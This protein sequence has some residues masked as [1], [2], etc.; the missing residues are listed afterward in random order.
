MRVLALD[1]GPSTGWAMFVDNVCVSLGTIKSTKPDFSELVMW[2]YD[3]G[4]EFDVFVIER[5]MIRPKSA[6]GF[7]HS[8]NSGDTLQIIGL[9][10]GWAVIHRIKFCEQNS[11]I[12]KPTHSIVYG[13]PY[14]KIKNNHHVDAAL[15]GVYYHIN[16]LKIPATKFISRKKK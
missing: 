4:T 3:M 16:T 9:L 7:D 15:H 5:Y 1:P 12:K 8:F 10:K 6:G 2:L 13:I 11:N 14:K